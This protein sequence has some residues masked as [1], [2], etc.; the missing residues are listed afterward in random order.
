MPF[1][2]QIEILENADVAWFLSE[3]LAATKNFG[4]CFRIQCYILKRKKENYHYRMELFLPTYN[5][6]HEVWKFLKKNMM[7]Y[8]SISVCV[9]FTI[10]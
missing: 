4:N 7:V 10:I 6:R 8:N 2:S 3:H 5:Q 1:L 9:L